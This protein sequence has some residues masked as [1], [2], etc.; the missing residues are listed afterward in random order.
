M[1]KRRWKYLAAFSVVV[2]GLILFL[3]LPPERPGVT[4]QQL[5][6]TYNKAAQRLYRHEI[7]SLYRPPEE[8][9]TPHGL[10]LLR[11]IQSLYSPVFLPYLV[12]GSVP[13]QPD[14]LYNPWFDL[15]ILV[16]DSDG[17]INS[18]VLASSRSP[19]Q[20]P[21]FAV[22][23]QFWQEIYRRYQMAQMASFSGPKPFDE[24]DR[25]IFELRNLTNQFGWPSRVQLSDAR[26]SFDLYLQR[27]T[28]AIYCTPTEPGT[29]VVFNFHDNRLHTNVVALPPYVVRE[30]EKRVEETFKSGARQT[31]GAH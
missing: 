1:K 30:V 6:V 16:E 8:A 5:K 26:V 22:K 3:C 28:Q 29:Y 11:Q 20:K 24:T 7:L 25:A 27:H 15:F 14:V 4:S 18:V 10:Q 9:F 13:V 23:E 19:D 21:Q 31:E 17:Q 2:A 12:M